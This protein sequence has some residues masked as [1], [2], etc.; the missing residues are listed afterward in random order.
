MSKDP[1]LEKISGMCT[2]GSHDIQN[3]SYH[4]LIQKVKNTDVSDKDLKFQ[5]AQRLLLNTLAQRLNKN[6]T[7]EL[8]L[9]CK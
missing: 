4:D 9:K 5:R 7:E 6:K 3:Q 2:V 1:L 8:A